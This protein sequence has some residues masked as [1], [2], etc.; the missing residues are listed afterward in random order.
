M[1]LQAGSGKPG[2][3]EDSADKGWS[4]KDF[5]QHC[6]I[7]PDD[8][9]E[10]SHRAVFDAWLQKNREQEALTAAKWTRIA[11]FLLPI[12]VAVA[13]VTWYLRAH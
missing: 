1:P 13:T 8:A 3:V 10:V 7:G 5:S 12:V 11:L 4:M 9:T 6:Q 2:F